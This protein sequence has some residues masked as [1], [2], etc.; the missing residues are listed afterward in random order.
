LVSVSASVAVLPTATLPK[1]TVGRLAAIFP[2]T[3]QPLSDTE[4]V[5]LDALLLN[6]IVPIFCPAVLGVNLIVTVALLPEPNESGNAGP[7]TLYATLL[8]TAFETVTLPGPLL[9]RVQDKVVVWPNITLPTAMEEGFRVKVA[10]VADWAEPAQT[11][12]QATTKKRQ[13]NKRLHMK[14]GEVCMV[15]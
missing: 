7:V 3:P 8:D 2:C 9:V 1:L 10:A 4:T 6:A 12:S 14:E 11:A 15:P 13:K 5:G